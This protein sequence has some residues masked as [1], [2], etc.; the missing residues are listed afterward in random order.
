MPPSGP[1]FAF[2]DRAGFRSCLLA[3]LQVREDGPLQFVHTCRCSGGGRAGT[4]GYGTGKDAKKTMEETTIAV[5]GF[6]I[7]ILLALGGV[8][9][10]CRSQ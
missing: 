7:T 8:F 4:V 3:R 1:V 2:R 10:T 6:G 9:V 5:V